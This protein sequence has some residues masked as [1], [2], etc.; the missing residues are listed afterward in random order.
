[1]NGEWRMANGSTSFEEINCFVY[2]VQDMLMVLLFSG[3]ASKTLVLLFF[4]DYFRRAYTEHSFLYLKWMS[5]S[6]F[7][8]SVCRF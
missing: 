1:M 5:S 4:I 7:F 2:A 8:G 3:K 6:D